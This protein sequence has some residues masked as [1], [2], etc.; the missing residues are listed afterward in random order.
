VRGA[1]GHVGRCILRLHQLIAHL[2]AI[3]GQ[4]HA[5]L[6]GSVTVVVGGLL[7]LVVGV[8]AAGE[9]AGGYGGRCSGRAGLA[10]TAAVSSVGAVAQP[11]SAI[12][13]ATAADSIRSRLPN[14]SEIR[15]ITGSSLLGEARRVSEGLP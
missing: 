3:F 7:P 14:S 10:A 13:P 2:R 1:I 9:A 11:A 6:S 12:A 4:A 15:R 8:L 5:A